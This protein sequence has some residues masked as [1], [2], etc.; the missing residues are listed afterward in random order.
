MTEII[1]LYFEVAYRIAGRIIHGK[2]FSDESSVPLYIKAIVGILPFILFA[3]IIWIVI[4]I[5]A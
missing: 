4:M 2:E 1:E 5:K 3:F